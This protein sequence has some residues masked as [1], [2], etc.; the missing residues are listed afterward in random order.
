[1]QL[2]DLI[3]TGPFEDVS[4][5]TRPT[6][7]TVSSY[8]KVL[9]QQ[10]SFLSHNILEQVLDHITLN[11]VNLHVMHAISKNPYFWFRKI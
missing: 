2:R 5:H 8:I 6:V 1:M 4:V 11:R 9:E 10:F 3:V 7:F